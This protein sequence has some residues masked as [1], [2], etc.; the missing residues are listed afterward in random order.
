MRFICLFLFVFLSSFGQVKVVSWNV[1]N[2][3]NSKSDSIVNYMASVISDADVIALQEIIPSYGGSQ[4]VA[5]LAKILNRRGAKWD[6]VVSKPTT[7]PGSERYAFLWKTAKVK[8]RKPAWLDRNFANSINREPYLATFIYNKKEFT[9]VSFHA[10][11]KKKQPETEI[12]FL[13]Y[14]PQLYAVSNLIFLGD[15]NCP[16]T[17]S[18]FNPLK[19]MGYKPALINQRTTLKMKCKG[20]Q[21][22]ASEYDNFFYPPNFTIKAGVIEFH[23][24]FGSPKSARRV[25][26]HLPIYMIFSPQ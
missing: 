16:Q 17:H 20:N 26:D 18:V 23:K 22:L 12:K 8:L 7:G 4:S 1:Q 21:C 19:K 9:L 11:P 5:R 14:F 2:F 10:V 3:G 15:F 24:D 13:K 6:Y 25:S